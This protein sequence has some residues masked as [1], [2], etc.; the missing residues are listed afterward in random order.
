MTGWLR[1]VLNIGVPVALQF[2]P[3]D[4]RG[5]ANTVYA[6]VANAEA[7]GGAGETK[8]QVAMRYVEMILPAITADIERMTGKRV[9]D[10]AALVVALQKLAE[11][12][13]AIEKAVGK[14]PGQ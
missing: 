12:F 10:G 6:G 9:I 11:F 13:V 4:F 8:L 3:R 14:R 2:V 5:V 1:K 7:A